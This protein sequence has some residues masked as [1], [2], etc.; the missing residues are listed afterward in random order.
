[1]CNQL[2]MLAELDEHRYIAQCEHGTIHVG[3][4]MATLHLSQPYFTV[5][6]QALQSTFPHHEPMLAQSSW[7]ALTRGSEG[8]ISLRIGQMELHLSQQDF[9]FLSQMMLRSLITIKTQKTS[10]FSPLVPY[11]V[12]ASGK[13]EVSMN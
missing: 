10:V 2:I 12:S 1:M 4:G 8:E 7:F 9:L 11:L 6:A 13:R 3:W 5:L